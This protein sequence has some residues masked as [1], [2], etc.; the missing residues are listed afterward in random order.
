MSEKGLEGIAEALVVRPGDTLI[1]RLA[2]DATPDQ[3]VRFR[4]TTAAA[5]KEKLPGV[6]V[7]FFGGVDQVAVYRPE[8]G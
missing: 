1:V 2:K 3:L 5:F 4:E 7:L 8:G 6:E